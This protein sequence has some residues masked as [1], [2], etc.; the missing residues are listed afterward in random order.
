MKDSLAVYSS[1]VT[2]TASSEASSAKSEVPLASKD[3]S[4]L[5][6]LVTLTNG[7]P[8]PFSGRSIFVNYAFSD[9]D[10]D[11]ANAP[12]LLEKT[13]KVFTITT[14]NILSDVKYF[15]SGPITILGDYLYVWINHGDL[16]HPVTLQIAAIQLNNASVSVTGGGGG[17]GLT[18]GESA[19]LTAIKNNVAISNT[20]LGAPA[21]TANT[22]A[23]TS[24]T[25]TAF[26]KGIVKI[27]A[28]VW[29]TSTHTLKVYVATKLDYVNDSITS[30]VPAYS[31]ET[32]TSVA[33][34]SS[35]TTILAA[36][37]SRKSASIFNNGTTDLY[38]KFGSSVSTSSFKFKLAPADYFEMNYPAYTG[39]ITGVWSGSPT[40]NSQI[41]EAA[42]A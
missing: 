27:L 17:G 22:V 42:W 20:A 18:S 15:N 1:P 29:D 25:H 16:G 31:V 33:A 14:T 12:N 30:F 10:L 26:L 32:Y 21:D 41:T 8:P 19:D 7:A 5:N 6:L 37:A 39:I 36:N 9:I 23:T 4:D 35:A 28:D 40:G 38:I 2:L 24:G 11:V 34:T 13:R 3:W